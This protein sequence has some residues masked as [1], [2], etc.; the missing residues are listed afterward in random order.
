MSVPLFFFHVI[1]RH[2][3]YLSCGLWSKSDFVLE[4]CPKCENW[5]INLWNNEQIIRNAVYR[6]TV[7]H[8]FSSPCFM[9]FQSYTKSNVTMLLF[10]LQ[11]QNLF[12]PVT[13]G[14]AFNDIMLASRLF[15]SLLCVVFVLFACAAGRGNWFPLSP[16]LT[17]PHWHPIIQSTCRRLK[18][19]LNRPDCQT[20]LS[21]RC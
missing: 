11:N 2:F 15:D 4:S 3:A 21:L 19:R 10:S 14:R 17:L 5:T 16:A 8:P 13:T 12:V 20:V 6:V 18:D 7:T 1:I 9:L